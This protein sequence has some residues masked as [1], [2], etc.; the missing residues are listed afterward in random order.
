MA[1]PPTDQPGVRT[2]IDDVDRFLTST[3]AV[4][5]DRAL[6]L[7]LKNRQSAQAG[8]GELL[9][10]T[11]PIRLPRTLER[12]IGKGE[13]TNI[14]ISGTE[15]ISIGGASTVSDNFVASELRQSQSLF[16]K[17][18]FEQSLRVNLDGTVGEKIK[19]RGRPF[20]VIGVVEDFYYDDFT[21]PLEPA[22]LI[23]SPPG[24]Y[25]FMTLRVRAGRCRATAQSMI[26][27]SSHMLD[28]LPCF[29]PFSSP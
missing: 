13:A 6:A 1:P 28:G 3:N 7:Q 14:R 17:L 29:R 20:T 25:L 23:M 5:R 24:Q 10:F 19:V 18:E 9:N 27:A 16:P 11:I 26:D 8:S 15:R 22:L 4:A 2:S 21:D 12:I